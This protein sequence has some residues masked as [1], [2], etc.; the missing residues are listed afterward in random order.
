MEKNNNFEYLIIVT[1]V[2]VVAILSLVFMTQLNYMADN[3]NQGNPVGYIIGNDGTSGIGGT[4]VRS[5]AP[6]VVAYPDDYVSDDSSSEDVA[7]R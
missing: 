4:V 7:R 1:L 2:V 3:N 5:T 6:A